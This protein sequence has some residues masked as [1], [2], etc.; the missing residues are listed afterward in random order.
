MFFAGSLFN[1]RAPFA[2]IRAITKW[3]SE[4]VARV[5]TRLFAGN[6]ERRAL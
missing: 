1:C 6:D 3:H 2:L 5:V 4:A